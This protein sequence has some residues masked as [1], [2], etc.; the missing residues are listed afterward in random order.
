M[1]MKKNLNDS[2]DVCTPIYLKVMFNT[3]CIAYNNNCIGR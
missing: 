1:V 3:I 2:H